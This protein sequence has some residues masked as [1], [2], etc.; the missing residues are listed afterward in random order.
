MQKLKQVRQK[1]QV[2]GKEKACGR[3]KG[4]FS[5]LLCLAVNKNIVMTN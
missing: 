3:Q 2:E 1:I 5:G 4:D